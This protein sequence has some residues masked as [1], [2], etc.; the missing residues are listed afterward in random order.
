M[1]FKEYPHKAAEYLQNVQWTSLTEDPNEQTRQHLPL[2]NGSYH[3]DDLPF[4][5]AELDK[6]LSRLKIN[7]PPGEDGIC[8]ELYQWL[9][10]ENRVVIL[11]ATNQCLANRYMDPELLR[12]LVASIYKKGD[13]SC[14][15]NYRP[16]IPC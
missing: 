15:A 1:P 6:V 3:I 13:S 2:E 12:A 10:T 11:K 7:E 14:L 9:D 8:A 4:T 5:T 16:V